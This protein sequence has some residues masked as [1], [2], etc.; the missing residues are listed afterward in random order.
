M[1]LGIKQMARCENDNQ[2]NMLLTNLLHMSTFLREL[3]SRILIVKL[4]TLSTL[5]SPV[6][7]LKFITQGNLSISNS[8]KIRMHYCSQ[9]GDGLDYSELLNSFLREKQQSPRLSM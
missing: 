2:N 5:L 6:D 7:L 3:H 4:N 8:F 1:C 9:T